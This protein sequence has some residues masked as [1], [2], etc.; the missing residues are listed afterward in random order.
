VKSSPGSAP[1]LIDTA[2]A[3]HNSRLIGLYFSAH[4]CGPCR[5][6]S[7]ILAEVYSHL[8]EEYPTHGLEIVFVSSDR[9]PA[10]FQQYFGSMP[11]MAVP[12]QTGGTIIPQIKAR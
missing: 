6:F 1:T 12:F 3:L 2:N 11:W 4:W 8:K 5:N 10:G 7:P 9:D